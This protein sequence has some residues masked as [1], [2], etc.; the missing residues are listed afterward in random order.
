[1]K[2]YEIVCN[3]SWRLHIVGRFLWQYIIFD[4]YLSSCMSNAAEILIMKG[5]GRFIYFVYCFR[6]HIHILWLALRE[7]Q[8]INN[9]ISYSRGHIV[10]YICASIICSIYFMSIFYHIFISLLKFSYDKRC[11]RVSFYKSI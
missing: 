4:T 1:M 2:L 8:S 3:Y 7:G 5:M 10:I 9:L 11:L 6:I